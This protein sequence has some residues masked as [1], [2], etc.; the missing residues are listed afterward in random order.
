MTVCR[1]AV[2]AHLHASTN[3]IIP[4]RLLRCTAAREHG[5]TAAR[6]H[7]STRARQHEST[8][9][10]EHGSTAARE[11]GSTRA[12]EHE[13]TAARQ[14]GSTYKGLEQQCE[15]L[16]SKRKHENTSPT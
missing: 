2:L 15:D 10:R 5:S 7:G 16:R 1:F 12:R 4:G 11:H 3:V 9:A 14:H 13:S 8:A 6:E